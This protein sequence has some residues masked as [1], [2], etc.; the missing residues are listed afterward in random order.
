MSETKDNMPNLRFP[1]FGRE[2][3]IKL[4]KDIALKKNE[5]NQDNKI[6]QVLTN[7][8][9]QGI[10]KQDDYFDNQIANDNSINGYYVV[11]KNDF[12]YNPRISVSAPV[13]PI[14][15]SNIEMGVMSPLYTVFTFREGNTLF[16][17]HY[18]DSTRWHNYMKSI[19]NFG[20]RYDRMNITNEDFFNLPLPFP[21]PSEQQKIAN[22]LSSIDLHIQLLK[23]KKGALE[24]YKK[25]IMQKIFSQKI[26][27]KDERGNDYPDWK[28]RKL[29]KVGKFIS[30]TG[31][32]NKEQGGKQGIPFYKV[33]DMNTPENSFYMKVANNYVA[34]E[35]AKR[36][37]YKV[38][39]ADAIIFAKVGGAIFLERKR[40]AKNFLIDNNMMSFV[41]EGNI[42]FFKYLFE[43]LHLSR[44]AQVGAL[45]SYNASDLSV[46]N[47]NIPNSKEQQRIAN[48]LSAIDSKIS[49]CEVQIIQ[50]EKYKKGL[51][52]QMFV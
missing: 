1:E 45:P 27:L 24:N 40:V 44:Y 16:Y 9:T 13:G 36:N 49:I 19:A 51:L 34:E 10:V 43:M 47:V 32:S 28:E 14:K 41:P 2:W 22:F 33:S 30:G 18:F 17:A 31:F 52:Q 21:S 20:A 8:A 5:K 3:E 29:G 42:I 35:Q 12:V 11:Q 25:G 48:F 38:I 46:I 26:R 23:E 39:R 50:S 6:N 7:S 15:K 4:L 37:A